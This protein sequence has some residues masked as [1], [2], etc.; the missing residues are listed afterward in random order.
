MGRV[1]TGKI[2]DRPNLGKSQPEKKSDKQNFLPA[3]QHNVKVK[4]GRADR[5]A[6]ISFRGL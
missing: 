1:P 6:K 5:C 4:T 3:G 2:S